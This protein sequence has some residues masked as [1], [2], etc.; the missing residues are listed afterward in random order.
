MIK[1]QFGNTW[2]KGNWH[3]HTTVS[4]GR[5][6]PE[7]ALALYRENGYDFIALTDHY[8]WRPESLEENGILCLS[9]CEYDTGA[10][11]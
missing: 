11:V 4:D 2:Y 5:K 3:T 7:E 1:D 6:T 9:G 8:K 10:D